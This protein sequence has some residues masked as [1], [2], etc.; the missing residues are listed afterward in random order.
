MRAWGAR[1]RTYAKTNIKQMVIFGGVSFAVAWVFNVWVMA[2]HYDGYRTP[3][4]SPATG[5]GNFFQGAI[6][7]M[8]ASALISSTISYRLLVGSERFW[9]EVYG[10]PSNIKRSFTSDGDQTLVHLLVGFSTAMLV[11]LIV[12]PSVALALAI[13]SL[14]V[15]TATGTG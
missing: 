6:F 1:A 10:I 8:L 2:D 7:Y 13:G 3:S 12:G 15:F 14:L 9:R 5:T 4:G 11:V